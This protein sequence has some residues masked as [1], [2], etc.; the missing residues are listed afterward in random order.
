MFLEIV[1]ALL[2]ASPTAAPT[3]APGAQL[4][5]IATVRSTPFCT[6]IG[7][8]FNAAVAPM[9]ANDRDLDLVD[10]QLTNFSDIF[11]HADY[12]IRYSDT[13]VKLITYVGDIRRSLPAVQMQINLLRNGETLTADKAQAAQLHLAAEKL[14]LAYN[15]QMQLST[16]LGGVI[17]AM[18]EYRPPANLD[19]FQE[20]MSEAQMPAEMRSIKSYLRFDGQRD[21]LGQAEDAAANQAIAL[22]EQHCALNK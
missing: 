10:V 17:Q 2:T 4:K 21:I 7:Q 11:H 6:S 15:K 8:H 9:L 5:T 22:V 14:Q 12:Q 3:A 19:V 18:M 20:E 1:L 13:R 16:D